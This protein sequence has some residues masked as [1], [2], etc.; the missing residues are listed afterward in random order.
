MA[1]YECSG[2]KHK[3]YA[4]ANYSH[5]YQVVNGAYPTKYFS[6][7]LKLYVDDVLMDTQSIPT[8]KT[9]LGTAVNRSLTTT[10]IEV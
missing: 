6:M 2:G 3:V 9:D 5:S 4:T 10:T 7:N 8:F 1:Y